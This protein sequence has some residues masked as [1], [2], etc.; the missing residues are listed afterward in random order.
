MSTIIVARNK[1]RIIR[2]R[3]NTNGKT[4]PMMN[5][6]IIDPPAKKNRDGKNRFVKTDFNGGLLFVV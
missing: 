4:N 3:R 1:S 2:A 6:K 5:K